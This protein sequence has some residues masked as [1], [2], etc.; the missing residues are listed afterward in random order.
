MP[1]ENDMVEE[2]RKGCLIL[3]G[4]LTESKNLVKCDLEEAK[5]TLRKDGAWIKYYWEGKLKVWCRPEKITTSEFVDWNLM[6]IDFKDCGISGITIG[7]NKINSLGYI[8]PPI[9]E[10][11]ISEEFWKEYAEKVRRAFVASRARLG[12]RG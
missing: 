7:V 10:P 6:N 4:E 8:S 9:E 3:K 12:R 1:L 11:H 2:F 5:I